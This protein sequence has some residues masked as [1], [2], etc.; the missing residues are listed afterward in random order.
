METEKYFCHD[1][2]KEITEQDEVAGYE[3]AGKKYYKCLA[4]YDKDPVLRNI[5]KCEVYSRIVGYLRPVNQ[6]NEGKQ[7]EFK[8]RVTFD[9]NLD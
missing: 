1:C 5:Q 4:C 6:W 2:G 3:F 9:K 8:E 7:E